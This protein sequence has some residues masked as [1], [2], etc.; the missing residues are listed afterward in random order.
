MFGAANLGTGFRAGVGLT[1]SPDGDRVAIALGDST[2]GQLFVYDL[3]RGS[4][5]NLATDVF[6]LVR[7]LWTP[8]GQDV[9]FASRR[10]SLHSNLTSRRADAAGEEKWLARNEAVLQLPLA[11]SPDGRW[12][13]Y[14]E[15]LPGVKT[16][17]LKMAMDSSGQAAPV[18]PTTGPQGWS[19]AAS[20]SPDGRWLA[21]EVD[22]A[23]R[24][25]IL[26]RRFSE[27]EARFRLSTSGGQSPVWGGKD[28]VFYWADGGIHVVSVTPRGES[29]EVSKP[30][31]LFET[32]D[33][34]RL[35]PAFDVL[36]DGQHFLMLRTSGQSRLSL[37]FNWPQELARLAAEKEGTS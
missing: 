5:S 20:F 8:R 35:T 34:T 10:E 12:L 9:I 4:L 27:G 24:T 31:L 32:G 3:A 26:V 36:P 22:E 1:L 16:K 28:E 13:V 18:F 19:W 14:A 21:Y 17:L 25:E 6:A 29:L 15:G 30:T 37:I 11:L 33:G 2:A 23:G 7:P